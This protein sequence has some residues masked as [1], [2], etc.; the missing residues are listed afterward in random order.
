MQLY[1][2]LLFGR[3]QQQVVLL[4][5]LNQGWVRKVWDFLT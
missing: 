2:E 1:L 4:E 5:V 3:E